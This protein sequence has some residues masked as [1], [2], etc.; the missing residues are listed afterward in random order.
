MNMR[1]VFNPVLFCVLFF[2]VFGTAC[3]KFEGGQSIPAYI[4]IDAIGLNVPESSYNTFGANTSNIT[5]AWVYVDDQII[6]CFE[7]PTT[8]PVLNSGKHKVSVYA[9]IKVN[10]I[11]AARAAYTFY[12]PCVYEQL[13]LV[14]DS[15]IKLSPIVNYYPIDILKMQ[16]KEDFESGTI[17]LNAMSASDT[18]LMRVSGSEALKVPNYTAY[19]GKIVLPP[20]SLHF[21]MSSFSELKT[22]P[23][24]GTPCMLELD[25]NCNSPFTVG[26]IYCENYQ[27]KEAPLVTV[28]ATDTLNALPH[29]WKKIYI[30]IGPTC[31]AHENA[32]YFKIYFTSHVYATYDD[33]GALVETV[34]SHMRYYYLDNLK[35]I[36]R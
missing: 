6:G 22:L 19:S 12:Q 7:L 27:E 10:G 30:N 36:S 20:D 4:R 1:K 9:G 17:T 8:F 32:D 14:P 23:T 26:V 31:V 33:H 34:P 5:D 25:Y 24:D 2:G 18:T 21:Y 35:L 28:Q 16:W 29:N 15:I 11:G 13:E 3:Q